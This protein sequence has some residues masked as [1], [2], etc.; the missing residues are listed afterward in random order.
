[1]TPLDVLRRRLGL[2]FIVGAASMTVL[3]LTLLEPRLR[4]FGFI[5]YW[6]VCAALAVLA[7]VT[8][9]LD[10]AVIRARGRAEREQLARES[11]AQI[12]AAMRE[13]PTGKTGKS[14][15]A[16]NSSELQ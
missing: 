3:G 16:G 10:L 8:A 11:A 1:M 15:P 12:E 6:L 2:G 7:L 13:A 5:V 4:G 9:A 14:A